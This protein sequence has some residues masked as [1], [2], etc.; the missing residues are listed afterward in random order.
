LS[1]FYRWTDALPEKPG[2]MLRQE[3]LPD[4]PEIVA[5]ATARRILYTSVDSRWR[6]GIIPVSGTLYLPKRAAPQGGWPLVAWAH[7]TLGGSRERLD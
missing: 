1:P 7:G 5:A 4:Q 2:L 3:G 6:S